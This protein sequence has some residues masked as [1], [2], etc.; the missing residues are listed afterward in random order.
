MKNLFYGFLFAILLI[1]GIWFA[2]FF[3]NKS[4]T[5]ETTYKT[6]KLQQKSIFK[7]TM[8][9]GTILPRKEVKMKSS[10]SGIIDKI[11]V[12]TGTVVEKGDLLA[13]I[14]IIP[15]AQSTTQAKSSI[16]RSELNLENARVELKR[17]KLLFE[18][19]IIPKVE[20]DTYTYNYDLRAQELRDA[21]ENL[22]VIKTGASS[23][24][25]K[26]LT[27]IRATISGT[28]LGMGGLVGDYITEA[29][30]FTE[31]TTI[32]TVADMRSVYF[33]GKVDES[34]V[35]KLKEGLP[36]I[37]K[38]GAIEDTEFEAV[39]DFISPKGVE[40]DKTVKF[41]IN[42]T[43][44]IP[45]SVNLRAGYSANA[46]IV[47]DKRENVLTLA[48]GNLIFKND[49]TF[50]E[51]ET[52]EQVFEKMEVKTGLSDGLFVEIISGID[53]TSNIKIQNSGTTE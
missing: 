14:K 39:L 49:S 8:A 34:E 32:A 44:N 26:T 19:G 17:N 18:K 31:G 5:P 2:T 51:V 46:E 3:Y 33:S 40:E 36:I 37:L 4:N 28:V 50:V 23:H 48:E 35:G 10:V 30:T 29:N 52:S 16:K 6:E 21:K 9:T 53:S 11:Y 42:A 25:K 43:I 20:F 38:V 22:L 12:G 41:S 7:K 47:L 24:D 15:N 1:G 45:D 27:N 13:K